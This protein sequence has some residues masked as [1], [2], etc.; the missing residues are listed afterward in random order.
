M[1][2]HI[3]DFHLKDIEILIK[4][5]NEVNGLLQKNE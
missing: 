3:S 4:Q 1:G 5:N 2:Q